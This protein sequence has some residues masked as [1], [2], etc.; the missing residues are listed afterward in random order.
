VHHYAERFEDA[1]A[2]FE[3]ALAVDPD[4]AWTRYHRA[5]TYA[6]LG[7]TADAVAEMEQ[8][9][10]EDL[11]T[12]GPRWAAEED[13]ATAR[14]TAEG[15]RLDARLPA[16][17]QAYRDAI[18]E[19]IPAMTY[20]ARAP[21]DAEG[22]PRIP[23]EDLRLGVYTPI[24]RRFVPA[25]PAVP[26]ALVGYFDREADRALVLAGDVVMGD[27]WVVQA[28]RVDVAIFDL[29]DPGRVVLQATDVDERHAETDQM[30]VAVQAALEGDDARVTLQQLRYD[31]DGT[32]SLHVTASGVELTREAVPLTSPR[33]HVDA[34]GAF[35]DV[36]PP[37][38]LTIED[39]LLHHHAHRL[40]IALRPGHDPHGHPYVASTPD[41]RFALVLTEEVGCKESSFT[42]HVLDRVDLTRGE[43]SRLSAARTHAG[44][45]LGPD[46]SVY[47]DTDGRV[48]RFP[49]GSNKPVADVLPGVRFAVPD[50]DRD[51][52][53]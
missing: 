35:V 53:I 36:P 33:V 4:D 51:C 12:Y 31:P 32:L 48:V 23:H 9:V 30:R 43:A 41:H 21:L 6:R 15:Q 20:R 39:Q 7:R 34:S 25:V 14:I 11:P 1:L 27:Y 8:L 2:S 44:A 46:G 22:Q 10:L 24:H 17:R 45:A 52:S 49:P 19:G 13:L 37:A 42:K 40:P 38:G 16:I 50:Y 5:R 26:H 28:R 18:A 29:A 3:E 47:L